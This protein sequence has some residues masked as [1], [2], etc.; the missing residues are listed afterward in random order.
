V[1]VLDRKAHWE[2]AWSSGPAQKA[3]WY[4]EVPRTSLSMINHAQ[5]NREQPLIDVGGGASVLVDH[6]LDARYRDITVLD[7]SSTALKQARH[8][9]GGKADRV[10]WI[11]ADITHYTANRQ[12]FLWHDRAAFHFLVDADDRRRY[13]RA[14]NRGL[15][16]GGQAIMACFA[17]DGPKKCSGLDIVQYDAEGLQS[18]LGD[19]MRLLEQQVE[20]HLTPGGRE[21]KFGFY[22]FERRQV[23][24]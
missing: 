4:Q 23:K 5:M 3:S 24:V 20:R 9:L 2:K 7:I 14:L 17:P 19:G 6:L 15:Q 21:Q 16:P 13:V 8:R 18:E 22:R 12:F 10:D 1:N 11:E